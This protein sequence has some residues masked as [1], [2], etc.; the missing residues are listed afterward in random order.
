MT[1]QRADAP[2]PTEVTAWVFVGIGV[3]IFGFAFVTLG[4]M[5]YGDETV[6]AGWMA[7]GGAVV[8]IAAMPALILTGIR[9]LIP[10]IAPVATPTSED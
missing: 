10:R 4:N 1:E 5:S 8:G 7:F 2:T 9:Q 6:P 3:V